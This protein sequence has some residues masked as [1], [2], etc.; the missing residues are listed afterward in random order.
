MH[1]YCLNTT[2]EPREVKNENVL[3]GFGTTKNDKLIN[4]SPVKLNVRVI[5]VKPEKNEGQISFGN[6]T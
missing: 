2:I 4:N 1:A 5:Q 6:S 3:F